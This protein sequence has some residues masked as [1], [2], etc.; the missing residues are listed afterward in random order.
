MRYYIASGVS[1]VDNCDFLEMFLWLAVCREFYFSLDI[2]YS[3][4]A[5]V[6]Y[7]LNQKVGLLYSHKNV[8]DK[9][10]IN[11]LFNIL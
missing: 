4:T 9:F 3:P 1:V 7:Y 2:T 5:I 10:E 11:F 6:S 8:R